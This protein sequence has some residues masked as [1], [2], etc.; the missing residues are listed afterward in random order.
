MYR[1]QNYPQ[2]QVKFERVK[3]YPIL[4]SEWAQ[5]YNSNFLAYKQYFLTQ[6]VKGT[7]M[8]WFSGELYGHNKSKHSTF[9]SCK[10]VVEY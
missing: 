6:S 1:K 9:N 4:L 3:L 7:L 10:I 5:S 2:N 8:L